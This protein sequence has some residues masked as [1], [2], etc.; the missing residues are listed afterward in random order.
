MVGVLM[1]FTLSQALLNPAVGKYLWISLGDQAILLS[2]AIL[3][4]VGVLGDEDQVRSTMVALNEA[5]ELNYLP[6]TRARALTSGQTETIAVREAGSQR[7]R[8]PAV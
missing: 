4:A 6:N 5:R 1:L 7:P 8:W 3:V 2:I